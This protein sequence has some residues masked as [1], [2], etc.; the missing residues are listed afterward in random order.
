MSEEEKT[1][2]GLQLQAQLF[3][4]QLTCGQ[5]DSYGW[6]IE[7]Q[8]EDRKAVKQYCNVSDPTNVFNGA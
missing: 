8:S 4:A 6:R 7:V 1:M 3:R 2:V 5:R